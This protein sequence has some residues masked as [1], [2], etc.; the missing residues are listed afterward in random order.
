MEWMNSAGPVH[1][2]NEDQRS[3]QHIISSVWGQ[4]GVDTMCQT[5]PGHYIKHAQGQGYCTLHTPHRTVQ[6][7]VHVMH[8][9]QAMASNLGPQPGQ[10]LLFPACQPTASFPDSLKLPAESNSPLTP[11]HHRGCLGTA[12]P[13]FSHIK[14]YKQEKKVSRAQSDPKLLCCS[15]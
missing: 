10:P 8:G 7:T 12:D 4:C 3:A 14:P 13:N 6:G 11:C 15:L 2:L 5:G 1:R 9:C